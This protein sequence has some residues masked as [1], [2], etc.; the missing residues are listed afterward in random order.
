MKLIDY[1]HRNN[2]TIKQFA[3]IAGIKSRT[4]IYRYVHG[5]RRPKA[6]LLLRISKATGGEVAASDFADGLDCGE[7]NEELRILK[8]EEKALHE[9]FGVRCI[10]S[11]Q[12][13]KTNVADYL[14]ASKTNDNLSYPLWYALQV[15][16]GRVVVEN[17]SKFFLDNKPVPATAIIKAA[18]QVLL[19][20]GRS[21]IAYPG[22]NPLYLSNA[23]TMRIS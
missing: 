20:S 15:L 23:P 11:R 5:Q 22:V 7:L 10:T 1:L 17:E 4:T 21:Q 8:R 2:I 14:A 3:G 16:E 12:W 18:N 9:N 19:S 6:E 13:D